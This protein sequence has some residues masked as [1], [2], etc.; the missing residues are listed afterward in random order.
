[1]KTDLESL[2]FMCENTPYCSDCGFCNDKGECEF[3]A[4]P[5]KWGKK[6]E[7]K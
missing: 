7:E 3:V 1:M 4:E 2:K 5:Y 6:K